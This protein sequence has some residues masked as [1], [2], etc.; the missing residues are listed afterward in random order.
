M[1]DTK[2]T[3]DEVLD[4]LARIKTD[5]AEKS[6]EIINTT[7][8]TKIILLQKMFVVCVVWKKKKKRL[9]VDVDDLLCDVC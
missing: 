4:Q 8:P 6:Q 2:K 7:M 3:S 9:T 1:A 5:I